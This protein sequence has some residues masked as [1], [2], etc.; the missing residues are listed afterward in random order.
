MLLR[1][2]NPVMLPPIVV[3]IQ[4]DNLCPGLAMAFARIFFPINLRGTNPKVRKFAISLSLNLFLD[5]CKVINR[6]TTNT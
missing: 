6:S 3:A 4:T 1:I 5:R 2:Q